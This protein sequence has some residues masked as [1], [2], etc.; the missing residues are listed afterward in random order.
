MSEIPFGI[1]ARVPKLMFKLFFSFL[2]F[3]RRVRKSTRKLKKSLVKGGMNR[4]Q[5]ADLAA[6]YEES[7][8]IRKLIK[9]NVGSSTPF[10]FLF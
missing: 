6:R 8:S 7:V 9:S 1:I 2:R 4:K 5:A 10:S 3:K